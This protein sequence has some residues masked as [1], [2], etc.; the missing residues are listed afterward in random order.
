MTRVSPHARLHSSELLHFLASQGLVDASVDTGDVGQRL[1]DW[2]NFRQAIALQGF[3]G[4]VDD[5]S[6]PQST[7]SA[8]I[9]ADVLRRRFAA[10]RSA[11]EDSIAKGSVPA[12][13]LVRIEM[14]SAELDHP[15]DPK[16]AFD[17]LRRF[18]VGHQRQMDT[19][20]RSLRAQLRGMLDKGTTRDRQ[21]SA[22]DAIFENVLSTRE[23]RLLGKIPT[24]FEKRFAKALKQHM[25]QL[26]QAADAEE[27]APP[28]SYTHLTLP[29]NR[30]V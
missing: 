4:S 30:E 12:L 11:L 25:K 20:I 1:G 17:P 18:A 2:L 13:G 24:E 27:P 21:L 6:A 14:P 26:V 8:R 23:A 5:P 28:V 16:T 9:D 7:P 19:I 3:I 15:I 10:V 29:T 22:L